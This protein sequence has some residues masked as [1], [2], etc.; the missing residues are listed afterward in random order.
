[1]E[2]VK[3]SRQQSLRIAELPEDYSVVGSDGRA[4]LVRKLNGQVLRVQQNGRLT[5]ATRGPADNGAK[6]ERLDRKWRATPYTD[7]CG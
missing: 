5:A 7:V 1:M 3:L 2:T 6:G 4:P